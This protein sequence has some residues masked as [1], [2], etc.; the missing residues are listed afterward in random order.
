MAQRGPGL[1]EK[2]DLSSNRLTT[3]T[4]SVFNYLVNLRYLLLNN[5]QIKAIHSDVFKNV[6]SLITLDLS[7]NHLT[8]F[9]VMF[10]SSSNFT[11]LR[12][13]RLSHN[14]LTSIRASQFICLSSLSTLDLSFNRIEKLSDCAFHGLQYNIRH[15]Y[16]NYNKITQ[17]NSCS[18][19][20]E[21]N[22]LRF[23]ELVHNPLNCSNNC[24]FFFTVYRAPYSIDY[25]GKYI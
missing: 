4:S 24:E 13:L 21:F 3:L 7:I 5:N 1:L 15:L 12:N 17:V 9:D 11:K 25:K 23:V 19:S 10:L 2:I 14:K 18:F 8:D 16:L 20:L 22:N 6:N